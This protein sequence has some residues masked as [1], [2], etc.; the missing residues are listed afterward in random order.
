[1]YD[2]VIIG[3]G[4]A[5]LSL[6]HYCRSQKLKILV[7][8]RE[9]Q[10]GGCH[11]VNRVN[12]NNQNLF[13][14]HG[15]RIYSSAYL[16]FQKLLKDMSLDFYQLFKP[17]YFQ[18][19]TGGAPTM[20][21]VMTI[22]EMS[23]LMLHFVYL[24]FDDKYGKNTNMHT[25]MTQNKYSSHSI[26]L[27]DRICR[28]SDGGNMYNYSLNQFLQTINQQSLYTIY[29]PTYETDKRLFKTWKQFLENH[30]VEFMLNTEVVDFEINKQNDNVKSCIVEDRTNK[31]KS[32][33][34]A[35]QFVIATPPKSILKIIEKNSLKNAFGNFED[36][37]KWVIDTNYITY[38]S[39]VFHW[40]TKL[41]LKN[42]YGFPKSDWGVS[43]IILSDYMA[44]EENS[45]KTVI[46]TAVTII[47]QKS[48]YNYKNANECFDEKD[49]IEEVFRQLNETYPGI[50]QPT[51]ALMT[52][53]N[54]YNHEKHSWESRDTAYLSAY[55]TN[56]IPFKSDKYSNLFNLGT[57][58]GKSSYKFTSME[59]AISNAKC[60][61]S[62]LYHG[63]SDEQNYLFTVRDILFLI[64]VTILVIV[65]IVK[66]QN[67]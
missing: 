49:F 45:S 23:I 5:G 20:L 27:I 13:T 12:V 51:T 64:L 10:I 2:L 26:S 19:L 65:F 47:D 34:D 15:P 37:K 21:E 39:V 57:H 36:F 44:F 58:N 50:P 53:N 55:Q 38:V 4:P 29:Q 7:I 46:S 62:E 3:G 6:A 22:R 14:E 16:H 56:Y 35:K 61:S 31:K 67:I 9:S 25:Y 30:N 24:L 8:E 42:T 1:M 48:R 18:V 59:T 54:F 33:L 63:L 32:K 17:Y 60:L 11:R 66:N 41:K 28:L 40:D 52:P 43:S